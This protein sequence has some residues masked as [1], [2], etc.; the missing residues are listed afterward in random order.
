ML[1]WLHNFDTRT[2]RRG[3]E[4]CRA[5]GVQRL[6]PGV[7]DLSI[8]AIVTGSYAPSY[9][10]DMGLSFNE[11]GWV[12]VE[13]YCDCPVFEQCKHAAA[14]MFAAEAQ[15]KLAEI[16]RVKEFSI[17]PADPYQPWLSSIQYAADTTNEVSVPVKKG[18]DRFLVYLL[19]NNPDRMRHSVSIGFSVSRVLKDGRW[20]EPQKA[21]Q[22]FSRLV[23]KEY[24][25]DIDRKLLLELL[26]L[27]PSAEFHSVPLNSAKAV[28]W[29]GR[30]V[31]TGRCCWM[32]IGKENVL[33]PGDAL[34][35]ELSW[36][37]LPDGT[38]QP[39]LAIGGDG[40]LLPMD[41]PCYV[42]GVAKTFG[43]LK[44]SFT[45][46]Q[47]NAW[48]SG[49]GV[50]P[51]DVEALSKKMDET[52]SKDMGIH[53]PL[54]IT[55]C[56]ERVLSKARMTLFTFS[57][58]DLKV[59]HFAYGSRQP[60]HAVKIEYLYGSVSVDPA[61]HDELISVWNGDTLVSVIR[62]YEAEERLEAPFAGVGFKVVG[63][64][65]YWV[66][67]SDPVWGWLTLKEENDFLTF[68]SQT[69]PRLEELGWDVEFDPSF[70][71]TLI[72]PESWFA[73]LE[74][75]ASGV[76]WFD[77]E[78]GVVVDGEKI[79]L[80]PLLTDFL[81]RTSVRSLNKALDSNIVFPL[82]EER[83]LLIPAE[84]LR[85]LASM[86]LELFDTKVVAKKE[87]CLQ[88]PWLRAMELGRLLDGESAWEGRL[89]ESLKSKLQRFMQLPEVPAVEVPK[90][91]KTEL[92]DYQQEGVSWMQ[93]LRESG[94]GAVL[95]DDMGLGKT[96]QALA[97][98]LIEKESGRL[99]KPCLIVAPTSVLYNWEDETRRFAPGLR[100]HVSHGPE[101]DEFFDTFSEYDLIVTSYPLL[102][103]DGKMLLKN[104]FHM[105]VLDEAQFVRN[106]KTQAA[107]TVR[108]L[109]AKQR[110]ALTG[111]PLENNLDDLWSLFSFVVPG[112]LGD[113][114]LFRRLFRV[115]IEKA[116]NVDSRRLLARRIAP[117]MLRRTKDEV[118]KELPPKTVM[119]Q[120]IELSAGQK[121]L[122]ETV[123]A[124]MEK[125]VRDAIR[126]KGLARSHII[127]LDALLKMRQVCCHP[128]LLKLKAA[129][130]VKDSAKLDAL[131]D[132]LLELVSEG[133]R[134]LLF[135]QFV[136]MIKLIEELLDAE[137]IKY[138]KLTGRTKDRKTPIREFQSGEVP[139]FLISLKAGGTG[140]NLTAADTVIHYD[141]W[142]NPAV[143]NQATDRAHRIG[144]DK[145]VFVYKLIAA[146]TVEDKI[147]ELQEK[148]SALINGLLSDQKEV[149]SK[150]DV[151]DIEAFFTPLQEKS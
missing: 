46:S 122:Y 2:L 111:T 57:E 104:E 58:K 18:D 96:V 21:V 139:V 32:E 137:N 151:A 55:H 36:A 129:E 148:K 76:D 68:L 142:W 120:H 98:I 136:S 131:R 140:L 89:P 38:Q 14:A 70:E 150:W 54:H 85:M 149:I 102:V 80:I 74:E 127:V 15:D 112:L 56:E 29:L 124:S 119:I 52:F 145:P 95:A 28:E 75:S 60:V 125:T 9:E 65:Y 20:G 5:G 116:G 24:V 7:E 92:R 86:L 88:I 113:Q 106:H 90:G 126:Q 66:D 34:K 12:T 1:E 8:S 144:Q 63:R 33:A 78:V 79:N 35:A 143:E 93:F 84:R 72:E 109:H 130:K 23:T 107:R 123:R 114:A 67:P 25:S 135:S 37:V 59:N 105:V 73:D 45:S 27:L 115:P 128:K 64:V 133:R 69:V 13:S 141:P 41:I 77:A 43:R 17:V 99:D 6:F 118:A 47:M 91:L 97:H 61:A 30:V 132:L 62:D 94:F 110:I 16:M 51:S 71:L 108:L 26:V 134:I 4:I 146:G 103:R 11:H 42:D 10:V 44:T 83:N 49:P 22:D 31:G 39:D 48:L 81:R 53:R 147:L 40:V 50:H 138:V 101:R 82:S 3:R 117:F 100:V 19:R 121:D 87:G